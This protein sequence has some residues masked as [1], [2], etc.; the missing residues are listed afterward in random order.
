MRFRA[1]ALTA[2]LAAFTTLAITA[3][4]AEEVWHHGTSLIGELKYPDKFEHF[5]FVNPQAPKG[6]DLRLSGTGSFDTLNPIPAKGDLGLGMGLVIESLITPAEDEI[7]S[8]Y[9]L[10][11]EAVKFPDDFS[12]VTYRL[13]KQ[14]RWHDG[15]P[16]T[17]EDVVWSFEQ[18]VANNPK[19]QFY[20]QHVTKAEKTGDHEVTFTFDEKNNREL[21]KIVGQ[22]LILPKHWW[23]GTGPDGKKRDVAATTLEPLMGSGPYR[24]SVVNPGNK[25]T[26]VRADDYW[27]KDLN[28]NVGQNNFASISYTYF[29]DLNVEFE[30][31]KGGV[32]DFWRENEARRWATGYDVPAVNDG[33]IKRETL[34]NPYRSQG[35]LVGFIPNLR[36][37]KFKDER[38]RRA[39][40]LAYDFE[41]QN[42]T[43]FYGQYQRINSYFFGTELASSGLPEGRELEI[44]EEVR[45]KVP[46]S[47]FTTPY[48]NPVGGTPAKLRANLG[49]AVK[50][51]KQAGYELRGTQMVN[52]TTGEPLG[53]EILLNG[54]TIEKVALSWAQNLKRIGIQVSVRS[55]DS[56]QYVNRERSRDFDMIYNGW[57]E[58]LSPGNEQMEY[59]GSQS[60][61][62][63]GSANYAGISD[64]AIDAL[65]RHVVFAKDREGLIAATKA[66]DR[67]LLA[68]NYVIP[69]YTSRVARIAYWDK[70]THPAELPT[71]SLGFPAAWWSKQA[72]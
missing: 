50:L 44:L 60:A 25:I 31:F 37:D 24:I 42:R 43:L 38:V 48:E 34:E 54:S 69:T 72:E 28:V 13:R 26:Y 1:R 49:E 5:D 70:L 68:E 33:R 29:A 30:A 7:A 41:D 36:R 59:W 40:N 71:Y 45:G 58:S 22:L 6:G 14:A 67:V 55:V 9:G 18:T 16:V 51:L 63:E 19:Q 20:Y 8:D 17:P 35:V 12:S 65:V 66:L 4:Q 39:L 62:R 3:A 15:E 23:E 52:S 56:S 61:N 46:D 57:A 10:L 53:F 2:M 11:A 27:G 47:V 21:P 32:I 64:P